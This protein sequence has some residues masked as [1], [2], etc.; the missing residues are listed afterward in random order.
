MLKKGQRVDFSYHSLA[1]QT[2]CGATQNDNRGASVI[3]HARMI[4]LIAISISLQH[5]ENKLVT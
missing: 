2:N 4:A 5:Y 3:T 1:Y